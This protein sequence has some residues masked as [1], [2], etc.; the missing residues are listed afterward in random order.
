MLFAAI[1]GE[2][3]AGLAAPGDIDEQFLAA[4]AGHGAVPKVPA[5]APP[6]QVQSVDDVIEIWTERELTILHA[7]WQLP[8]WR[9]AAEAA[10]R[11]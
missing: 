2:A 4:A 3:G 5:S 1:T 9:A 10:A 11:W 6:V 8:G 7:A